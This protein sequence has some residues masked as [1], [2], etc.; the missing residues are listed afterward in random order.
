MKVTDVD[1]L[2]E[3][4]LTLSSYHG[5]ATT[6]EALIAGLPLE[7]RRLTPSLFGRAAASVGLDSRILRAPLA[8]LN[9]SLLPAV[10]LLNG[11]R[12]CLLMAVAEGQC[13]VIWPELRETQVEISLAELEAQYSGISIMVRPKFRFDNR[14]AGAGTV[15]R[16]HWFW[17]A[18]KEN[19]PVYRDVL[20]AAFFINCFALAMPFFTMNVYDRVVPNYALET[21]WMLAIGI[22]LI[23]LSDLLLRTMR[24]YFLDLASRRV[25]LKL[26]AK[27]MARVLGLRLEA[28]PQSSGSFAA[29]LR[30]FETVR[31]FITSASMAALID[32]PFTLVF[33]A[34]LFWIAGPM[35]LPLLV[36]II[37]VVCYAM[38]T[39]RKMRELTET[40]YRASAMRNAT[41]IES[42][43]GLDTLKAVGGESTMQRKW[44]NSAAFLARSGVQ[45]RLLSNSNINLC[46]WTQ[47]MVALSVII[48]GVYL[49]SMGELSM[50]GLIACSMLSARG[51]APVAQMAGLLAQY[52]NAETAL[53]SLNQVM[54]MPIERPEDA[55]F[56]SR[57]E[58]KGA[59]EFRNVSF[60][61]PESDIPVLKNVS[62]SMRPGEHVAILGKIGSGKTTLQKLAMGL[63]QPTE[64]AVLV[65]GIDL[66][67]LDPAE[68]RNQI[69]Y[70]PQTPTLFYG[71]LKENLLLSRPLADDRA[72]VRAAEIAGLG[73][74]INTHPQGFDMMVGERGEWLSG[75]QRDAV[76]IARAVLSG[77][78]L[79]LLDEPTGSM[80][81]SSES[82]VKQQLHHFC[83]HRT[84]MVITHRN[85]LLE[86]VDR[87]IVVHGGQIVADGP[88]DTVIEALRQG[89]IGSGQ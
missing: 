18:L 25:D 63:Y 51:M 49:I 71:T 6:R 8:D 24:A 55:S 56:V 1:P 29:N 33:L 40:T 39:Q 13:R 52:H 37:V 3:C 85:S 53:K 74:F 9:A 46:L 16:G 35:I 30:S 80:D 62:F 79:L 84:M 44:E 47:Q 88:K 70:V 60:S 89:R 68:L 78:A 59:I 73:E 58:I 7:E 65:D 4:L 77:P 23:L 21:L 28:R 15:S 43:V 87:I 27:I 10:L 72:L 17:Q 11:K 81:H 83:R 67:Q 32:L 5:R 41:L 45:L 76:A 38:S 20:V 14:V 2:V 66:R 64:G 86:L 22:G 57:P 26:S 69:G 31:D 48:L 19:L 12:A 42:L 36:G 61:Y 75:G 34:V 82:W 54:E 50:G